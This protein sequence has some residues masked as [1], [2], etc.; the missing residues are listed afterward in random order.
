MSF[1][2]ERRWKHLPKCHDQDR[3]RRIEETT[4]VIERSARIIAPIL[5]L[6]DDRDLRRA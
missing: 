6:Q 5:G 4:I 3:V 2:G 1:V